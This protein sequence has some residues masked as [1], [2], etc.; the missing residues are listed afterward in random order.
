MILYLPLLKVSWSSYTCNKY[1]LFP[2]DGDYVSVWSK[3]DLS[4]LRFLYSTRILRS[5]VKL[6]QGPQNHKTSVH[7]PCCRWPLCSQRLWVNFQ[8]NLQNFVTLTVTL[9]KGI[10]G[11]HEPSKAS[12]NI[13]YP[14]FQPEQL[15]QYI[16]KL[17]TFRLPYCNLPQRTSIQS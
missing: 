9:I 7:P 8:P 4:N 1:A 3:T 5:R 11:V 14:Q 17:P 2:P 16:I 10:P 6:W 13:M 12:W 15:S